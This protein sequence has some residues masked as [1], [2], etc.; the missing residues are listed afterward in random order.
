MS[1]VPLTKEQP[2]DMRWARPTFSG[3]KVG[4]VSDATSQ[5]LYLTEEPNNFEACLKMTVGGDTRYYG[6]GV[7][8][9][10]KHPFKTGKEVMA[11]AFWGIALCPLMGPRL[12]R[13][14]KITHIYKKPADK[15][16]R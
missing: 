6:G 13:I 1:V 8:S 2:L 16:H 9:P 4:F 10:S 5:V 7:A 3:W 11:S 15:S 12:W 14:M